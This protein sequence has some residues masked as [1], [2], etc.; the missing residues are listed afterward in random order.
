MKKI[1]II[2]GVVVVVAG[3]AVYFLFLAPPPEPE[4]MY[5]V[6]GDYFVTNIADSTRLLKATIVLEIS[7][8]E[9]DKVTDYLTENNHII[10][11]II[12]FTLRSKTE[13][14]L[15]SNGIEETLRTEIVSNLKS[16]M[17]LDYITTIYFN[18]YVIQ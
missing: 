11:D 17:G 8:T 14:E 1:L 6:P 16:K 15:R 13:A 2:I 9:P 3:A 7:T 12:V 18:D 4:T 5:Y 10:R